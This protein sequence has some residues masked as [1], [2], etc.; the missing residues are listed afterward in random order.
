M[1]S[2]KGSKQQSGTTITTNKHEQK[3]EPS[4]KRKHTAI[5]DGSSPSS[6]TLFSAES[7]PSSSSSSSSSSLVNIDCSNLQYLSLPLDDS[8][9]DVLRIFIKPIP[10]LPIVTTSLGPIEKQSKQP[11]PPLRGKPFP[12]KDSS[13]S[14]PSNHTI[15]LTNEEDTDLFILSSG[16]SNTHTSA[17]ADTELEAAF[18]HIGDIRIL[19]RGT[20]GNNDDS[21]EMNNRTLDY[22]I[23]RLPTSKSRRKILSM[24]SVF[25]LQDQDGRLFGLRGW[26]A[27]HEASKVDARKLQTQADSIVQKYDTRQEENERKK[28]ELAARMEADGFTLVNHKLSKVDHNDLT[29]NEEEGTAAKRKKNRGSLVANDFYRFQQTQDKLDRLH[30]LKEQFEADKEQIKLI[31]EKRVFKPY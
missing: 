17:L 2:I 28:D 12:K 27:A 29:N 23:V 1:S 4:K 8:H 13:S 9:N 10:N 3:S 6:K 25:P 11:P 31:K 20:L 18:A 15:L 14:S 22:V 5:T 21:S 16:S 19:T 30:T 24:A 26:L 7:N